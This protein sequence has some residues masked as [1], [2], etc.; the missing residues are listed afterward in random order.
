M[1]VDIYKTDKKYQLIVAD[2]PWRQSKGGK[3][4][5]RPNSS[6]KLLDYTTCSLED[7][8]GHLK[9]ADSLTTDNSILF[10]WT[11]DKYLYEAEQIAKE[12]GYKL[13]ARIVWNKINGIPA[14]FTI[15]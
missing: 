8:K 4:A 10:L 14:A 15:R 13:H 6:G 5:V 1:I 12:L 11:I 3:K 9:V 2:P 7:I